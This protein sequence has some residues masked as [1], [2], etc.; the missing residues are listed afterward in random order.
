MATTPSASRP[1]N[2]PLASRPG[3]LASS[4]EGGKGAVLGVHHLPPLQPAGD[5]AGEGP[6]GVDQVGV[7][8]ADQPAQG[9]EGRP[10]QGPVRHGVD[11]MGGD[12]QGPDPVGQGAPP[13]QGHL[14]VE[15]APVV[16]LQIAEQAPPAAADVGIADDL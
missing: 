6:V 11:L 10:V 7:Q 8:L 13:G 14:H 4:P 15:A 5:A 9:G 1:S 2:S 12:V 3:G 16:I